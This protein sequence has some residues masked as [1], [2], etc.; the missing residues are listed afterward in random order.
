MSVFQFKPARK[1]SLDES[2]I[3]VDLDRLV[4][5]PIGFRLQGKVHLIKPLDNKTFLKVVNE[6]AKLD[7]LRSTPNPEMKV[8]IDGYTSLFQSVCDTITKQIVSDMNA[9][10]IAALFQQIVDQ[11][12]GRAFKSEAEKK[13]SLMTPA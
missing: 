10:Q 2:K 6:L 5:E 11:I 8:V 1:V 13:N 3:V 12:T 9:H 7:V 4:S